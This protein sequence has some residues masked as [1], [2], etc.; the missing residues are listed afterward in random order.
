MTNS[1]LHSER[2]KHLDVEEHAPAFRQR[3]LKSESNGA[4]FF[5]ATFEKKFEKRLWRGHFLNAHFFLV[6]NV[7]WGNASSSLTQRAISRA[8]ACR[9]LREKHE[10]HRSFREAHDDH[11]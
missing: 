3:K 11:S 7:D 2:L 10:P 6:T 5:C 1:P 4:H 8:S 9:F